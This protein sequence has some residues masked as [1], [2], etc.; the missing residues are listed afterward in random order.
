MRRSCFALFCGLVLSVI[1][2]VAAAPVC[3]PVV[4]GPSSRPT[5]DVAWAQ[6]P[7]IEVVSQGAESQFPDAAKFFL[8]V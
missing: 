5:L 2:M 6:G 1:L 7:G 3:L 8:T 4:C